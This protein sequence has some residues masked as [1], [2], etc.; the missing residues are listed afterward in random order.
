MKPILT[1]RQR[2]DYVYIAS[3]SVYLHVKYM[4]VVELAEKSSRA[5]ETQTD[6]VA[7]ASQQ[8]IEKAVRREQAKLCTRNHV[9]ACTS[10]P[11]TL[12]PA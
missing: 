2:V 10:Q 4:K 5:P 6:S 7:N 9:G 8:Q 3:C 1:N 12:Q 11:L